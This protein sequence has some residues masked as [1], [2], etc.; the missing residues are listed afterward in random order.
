M[1][2]ARPEIEERGKE[3]FQSP[4]IR[5]MAKLSKGRKESFFGPS[6]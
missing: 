6:G 3:S 5:K 2:E 1:K 4:L